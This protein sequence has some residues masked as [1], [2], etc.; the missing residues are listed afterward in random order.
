MS[1]IITDA[2]A[3]AV[4]YDVTG[5]IVAASRLVNRDLVRYCDCPYQNSTLAAVAEIQ[6]VTAGDR[7]GGTMDLVV[8]LADAQTF[9]LLAVVWDDDAA[10]VQALV[11]AQAAIDIT[12]YVAGD[13]AVT[14]GAFGAAGGR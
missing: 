6:D 5:D 9:T 1:N 12:D 11:D 7:T 10:T 2:Q 14:G 8:T 4:T 13:I 3:R